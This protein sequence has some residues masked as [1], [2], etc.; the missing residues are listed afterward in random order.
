MYINFWRSWDIYVPLGFPSLIN[1]TVGSLLPFLGTTIRLGCDISNGLMGQ[2]WIITP[3]L[4][5]QWNIV[6][7]E[8]P[9]SIIITTI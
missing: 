1:R 4:L 5:E 2:I 3:K 7:E 9:T 6:L 8:E